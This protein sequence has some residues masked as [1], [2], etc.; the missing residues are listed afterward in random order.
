MYLHASY[1][2]KTLVLNILL[3]AAWITLAVVLNNSS[4]SHE[5]IHISPSEI[6]MP[7]PLFVMIPRFIVQGY[8]S[9]ILLAVSRFLEL[10]KSA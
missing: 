7:C 8:F 5:V 10:T 9:E 1:S 3:I 4:I 6:C 2:F